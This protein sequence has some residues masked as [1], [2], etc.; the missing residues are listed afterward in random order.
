MTSRTVGFSINTIKFWHNI[1]TEFENNCKFTF[2]FEM[3][4][5]I[6]NNYNLKISLKLSSD[7]Q[8]RDLNING[9]LF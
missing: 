3:K 6:L 5:T 1:T 2:F 4:Q 9:V 7:G 8:K